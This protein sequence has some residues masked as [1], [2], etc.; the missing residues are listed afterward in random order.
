MPRKVRTF[1]KAFWPLMTGKHFSTS[2]ILARLQSPN[3][4][5][6]FFLKKEENGRS[7]PQSGRATEK[8]RRR[9]EH[10]TSSAPWSN[11]S[12]G[13]ST[14]THI[15]MEDIVGVR[16]GHYFVNAN[17]DDVT[18]RNKC[19]V[20]WAAHKN[21]LKGAGPRGEK[22]R[23]TLQLFPLHCVGRKVTLVE[24]IVRAREQETEPAQ[25]ESDRHPPGGGKFTWPATVSTRLV[26]AGGC[27]IHL[28]SS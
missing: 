21:I 3:V 24:F 7:C 13:R 22:V 19:T 17:F 18:W 23:K 20:E 15:K 14:H 1:Q 6:F 12:T 28:D 16:Q 9:E 2:S 10:K 25:V 11:G 8:Y 27:P 26:R 5:P 4:C